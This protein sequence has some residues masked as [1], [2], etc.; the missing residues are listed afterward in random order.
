MH[1]QIVLSY[2]EEK[3]KSEMS[4]K[5]HV[6]LY[7]LFFFLI[8]FIFPLFCIFVSVHLLSNFLKSKHRIKVYQGFTHRIDC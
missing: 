2:I 1:L 8:S 4:V 7:K 3:K 5:K 6:I